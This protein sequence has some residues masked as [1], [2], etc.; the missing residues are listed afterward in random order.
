MR[1]LVHDYAGHPFQVGLSRELA[2]RGH[3]VVHA[4]F[5]GD[6]GPKGQL[7]CQPGDPQGLRFQPVALD[8]PYS[9]QGLVQRRLGDRAYGQAAAR[10][11]GAVRPDVILSGNTP[12]DAQGAL[13]AGAR[14]LGVPMVHWCQDIFSLAVGAVLGQRHPALGRVAGA[15]YRRAERAQMRASAGVVAISGGIADELRGWGMPADRLHVIENWAMVDEFPVLP[16]GND[17]AQGHGLSSG[18]R[19]LCSGTMGLKHDPALALSLA[20]ASVAQIVVVGAGVGWDWLAAQDHPRLTCLPLQPAADLPSVLASADVLFATLEPTAGRYSVPSKILSYLCAGRPI[21]LAAPAD[22]AA[23]QMVTRS[24]A[25]IVVPP[26]DHG[27]AQDA[28]RAFLAD[29]ARAV[30]AGR[31]GRAFAEAQFD[32]ARITDRFEAVLQGAL[33]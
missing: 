32:I 9:K 2:R 13:L 15:A 19:V 17:W 25:G 11:V 31:Q 4:W 12:T 22:N 27:T 18:P 5:A 7:A 6:I 30:Q 26:G 28:V 14:R 24:G 33:S 10:L 3:E 20:R 16:K 21:V 8:R 23:A 1:V 29:P